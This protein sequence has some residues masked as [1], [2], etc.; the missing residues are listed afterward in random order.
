[1]DATYAQDA[2][3]ALSPL[4]SKCPYTDSCNWSAVFIFEIKYRIRCAT[5][6]HKHMVCTRCYLQL[7]IHE[8]DCAEHARSKAVFMYMPNLAREIDICDC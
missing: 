5:C 2:L 8:D 1:M 7:N 4:L 6:Y 3:S